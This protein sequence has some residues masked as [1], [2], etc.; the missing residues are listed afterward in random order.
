MASIVAIARTQE[1]DARERARPVSAA[2]EGMTRSAKRKDW[3]PSP[4]ST[5]REHSL[6]PELAITRGRCSDPERL[7]DLEVTALSHLFRFR[8]L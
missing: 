5:R 2:M 7:A 4:D 6:L 1:G 3:D 8:S